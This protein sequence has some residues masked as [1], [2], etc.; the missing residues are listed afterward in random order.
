MSKKL[1]NQINKIYKKV[2]N[3]IFN[4]RAV[5]NLLNNNKM[6]IGLSIAKLS[7][8]DKF[9][10]FCERFSKELAKMGLSQ[11]RGIWRKYFQAARSAHIVGLPK[12]FNEFELQTMREAVDNNFKMIKSIP[13]RVFEVMN[14]K[15][16]TTL[17]EEVIKGSVSR[18]S[19]KRLL[20]KH[21]NTNAKLVART[22]AAKLQTVVLESRSTNLGSVAYVWKASNDNR[23]RPSHKEM[24]NVIVFWKHDKPH[25]DNMIG[26]AGEF[27]N[28]RCAPLPIFDED[29]FPNGQLKIYNYNTHSIESISKRDLIA[30][31]EK[32]QLIKT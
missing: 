8:S 23:T 18:G 9:N 22:E 30:S 11:Q 20:E 15:Y 5:S 27:P 31:L 26:H 24:N 28:C 19:F 32:N 16:T 4:Q 7:S 14:H 1:E 10:K 29:D 12:T 6:Q 3:E 13:D 21:G 2:F 17:I 25:L